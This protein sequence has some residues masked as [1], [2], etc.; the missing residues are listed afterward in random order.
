MTAHAQRTDRTSG[1]F[2]LALMPLLTMLIWS[3]N[4]IVTK[5]SAGLIEPASIAFYRWLIALVLL[6]PFVM[7]G[8]W[9]NRRVALQLWPK[10]A[11]LGMLG[12]VIY[13]SLAYEAAKTTTALNMGLL[14]ALMPLIAIFLASAFAGE[15]LTRSRI[16]G[17]ILSLLGVIYLISHGDPVRLL[18]GGLHIGD[19]LMIVA[20]IANSF[21]G[22]LLKRWALPLPMWQQ[23]WCQIAVAT[24]FL[25][26]LWLLSD[27]SPVTADN[28]PLILFAA[29]PTSLLAPFCWMITVR[30]LG[31]ARSA[32]Y[33]N[34]LPLLVA[35]L[36]WLLLGET[37]AFFHLVGGGMALAGVAIGMRQP[38]GQGLDAAARDPLSQGA[39][40]D[41]RRNWRSR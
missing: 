25:L 6:T 39:A 20:I 18:A 28:L 36:A 4:T 11:V 31:A 34:L 33:I 16:L 19:A 24:A 22:V 37:L 17:G 32:L 8:L 26:P 3:G 12:M 29:I 1:G 38:S 13:Q 14:A 40:L 23:I 35:A 41:R 21:Y 9:G 30:E 10:L 15:R 5:A 27:I 2:Y 7:R